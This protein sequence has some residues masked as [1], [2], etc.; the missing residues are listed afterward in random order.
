MHWSDS[1]RPVPTGSTWYRSELIG[2]GTGRTDRF[3]WFRSESG[4]KNWRNFLLF[5]L[6]CDPKFPIGIQPVATGSDRNLRGT[7]KTSVNPLMQSSLLRLSNHRCR[8]A[9]GA[10]FEPVAPCV[11]LLGY[12]V[13]VSLGVP[14]AHWGYPRPVGVQRG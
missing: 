6:Y 10:S 7:A 2:L 13:Q 11:S 3:H 12:K 4:W 5:G 14:L 9:G 1:F 8:L